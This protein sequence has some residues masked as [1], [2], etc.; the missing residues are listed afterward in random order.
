MQWNG[1][2]L[3]KWDSEEENIRNPGHLFACHSTEMMAIH[4]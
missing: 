4:F 3:N 2:I 1:R